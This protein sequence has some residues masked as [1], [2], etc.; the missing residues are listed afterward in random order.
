VLGAAAVVLLVEGLR[1]LLPLVSA[2]HGAAE[3]EIVLFGLVLMAFMIFL[4]G[5]LAGLGRK[6]A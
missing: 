4:P 6:P 5:G 2:S 3:Y 1:S